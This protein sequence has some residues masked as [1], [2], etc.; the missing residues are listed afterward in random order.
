MTPNLKIRA[1]LMKNLMELYMKKT[2]DPKSLTFVIWGLK[3]RLGPKA[4][5]KGLIRPLVKNPSSN[6]HKKD[7]IFS[8]IMRR[9]Q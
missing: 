8:R 2:S 3:T 6:F 7:L 1:Y 4:F 5:G 9:S